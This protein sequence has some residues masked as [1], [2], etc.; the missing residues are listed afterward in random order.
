[1]NKLTDNNIGFDWSISFP[2]V[3]FQWLCITSMKSKFT[4]RTDGGHV[5]CNL[6]SLC[7]CCSDWHKEQIHSC[8]QFTWTADMSGDRKVIIS[9][10]VLFWL[11]VENLKI[12]SYINARRPF[13]DSYSCLHYT[14]QHTASYNQKRS[15]RHKKSCKRNCSVVH[16]IMCTNVNIL[17][18]VNYTLRLKIHLFNSFN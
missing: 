7:C 5:C 15:R 6:L 18:S 3:G 17:L 4:V 9:L 10:L 11:D 14:R 16:L 12:D 13:I 2:M 8:K 1:M